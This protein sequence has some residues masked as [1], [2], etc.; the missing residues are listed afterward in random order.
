[1]LAV[2]LAAAFTLSAATGQDESSSV[3]L[4]QQTAIHVTLDQALSSN[5]SR[6]GDHFD[7]TV[8]E[9]VVVNGRTVIPQGS[10]VEGLVVDARHSGRLAGRPR[11]ELDLKTVSVDGQTYDLRT[12]IQQRVGRGHKKR[13]FTWIA[14][15]AVGGAAIGAVV[16]GGIGAVIG[17]PIGAGAGTTVAFLKGKHDIKL[18]PEARLR[19]VLSEPVTIGAR[20]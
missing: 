5:H 15:G 8:A 10:H 6:P 20:S 11:L 12:F 9:D 7:A 3:T 19:F 18:P 4:P 2:A 17:A 16:G 1:M 14:G 13:N